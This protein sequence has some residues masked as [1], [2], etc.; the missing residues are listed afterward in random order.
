MRVPMRNSQLR[1][2]CLPLGALLLVWGLASAA[3]AQFPSLVQPEELG[4]EQ[5]FARPMPTPERL[6][7]R[8]REALDAFSEALGIFEG[9]VRHFDEATRLIL[10]SEFERR[11][12][13]IQERYAGV[14]GQL[15]EALASL[16]PRSIED[17]ERFVARYPRHPEYTPEVLF[18]LAWLYFDE[19]Q[20]RYLSSLNTYYEDLER[21]NRGERSLPPQD[22]VR[23]LRDTLSAFSRLAEGF[24]G[25]RLADGA[26]Y[27]LG[28][29]YHQL[30][31]FEAAERAFRAL[32][33]HAP[34]SPFASQAW[35]RV[36]DYAFEDHRYEEAQVA[37]Q[38]ILDRGV[39]DENYPTALFKMGWSSY[40]L[41]AF[42][43]ALGEFERLLRHFDELRARGEVPRADVREEALQYFAV[44]LAERDW[45]LDGQIDAD[46]LGPRLERYLGHGPPFA[47]EVID[48]LYVA[49]FG[50][51]YP[52]GYAAACEEFAAEGEDEHA[53]PCLPMNVEFM[54]F[55]MEVYRWALAR[56]PL[57]E[58]APRR[59][60][61]VMLGELVLDVDRPERD[62]RAEAV[63]IALAGEYGPTSPWYQ[64]QVAESRLEAIVFAEALRRLV[65]LESAEILFAEASERHSMAQA[66]GDAQGLRAAREAFQRAWRLFDDYLTQYPN[67]EETY[68]VRLRR[69]FS[70]YFAQDFD[71]ALED[72]VWVRETPLSAEFRA[73]AGN[74]V[75]VTLTE[76]VEAEIR[77]GRME[78]RALPFGRAQAQPAAAT[79]GAGEEIDLQALVRDV[80]VEESLPALSLRLVEA[81]DRF[82][83]LELVLDEAPEAGGQYALAAMQL[84]FNYHH[85]EEGR[86]RAQAIMEAFC[87]QDAAGYAGYLLI[88]S[89]QDRGD[90]SG[91]ERVAGEIEAN[92]ECVRLAGDQQ[93]RFARILFEARLQ[94]FFANA[95]ELRNARRFEEAAEEFI[96]FADAYPGRAESAVALYNAGF[97][98]ETELRRY[99]A[100]LRQFQRIITEYPDSEY[101]NDALVR[102]AVNS[103]LFFDFERAIDTYVVL[104]QRNV[105][106]DRVR[107]PL[108][109][110]AELLEYSQRYQEA[111]D[112]YLRFADNSP[113]S[114][115]APLATYRAALM[116]EQAGRTR[117]MVQTL[118]RFISRFGNRDGGTL[119]NIDAAVLDGLAR[120]LEAHE[121]SGDRRAVR[122]TEDQILAE[123]ARRRPPEDDLASRQVA[124]R[125]AYQR[126]VAEV[127]RWD[128][129]VPRLRFRPLQQR[130]IARRDAVPAL[131][132]RFTEVIERYAHPEWSICSILQQGMIA[133]RF[134]DRLARLEMPPEIEGNIDAEDE[135][136]LFFEEIARAYEDE[137]IASWQLL[138]RLARDQGVW[139]DCTEDATR[140]LN[141]LA[142]DDFPLFK[143]EQRVSPVSLRELPLFDVPRITSEG[144][145]FFGVQE[146]EDEG[147]LP[148]PSPRGQQPGEPVRDDPFAPGNPFAD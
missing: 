147:S 79:P 70:A 87:G 31:E 97:V 39:A 40:L 78:E 13:E 9:E 8:V 120:I 6:D 117:Q 21:Y 72:F 133:S 11:R 34:E 110:A 83:E 130:I 94:G 24:P 145:V 139:N 41:N 88:L 91:M 99:E 32:V 50:M 60:E 17:F 75:I 3:Y 122:A 84:Y 67:D 127:E 37:Y 19:A 112:M 106:S 93:E 144:G 128:E 51:A 140:R 105:G 52:D 18:R 43:R 20:A 104:H 12:R 76:Q 4:E 68:H 135:F 28:V 22:P 45:D 36:G 138:Y 107:L 49:F 71:R 89:Y 63:M 82:N 124:A 96:R 53:G 101:V 38:M 80:Q 113:N 141:R 59:H 119:I 58:D 103:R 123:F 136:I 143:T 25:H 56:L 61:Q 16:R 55:A 15:D 125:I 126:A 1:S 148:A 46:F 42:D 121:T 30:G 77:A 65:L 54:E 7:E 85:L 69:G 81:W 57:D 44:V 90:F 62:R 26:F 129:P 102:I 118:E 27:M 116:Y 66:S 92:S 64:H 5:A 2:R 137:A 74:Y 111:G 108:L 131:A 100:A 109:Q 95:N 14:I 23:D 134:A 146:E 47:A 48:R 114:P 86:R 98:Y 115:E 35:L 73:I 142:G 10:Q 29:S 132:A 33:R